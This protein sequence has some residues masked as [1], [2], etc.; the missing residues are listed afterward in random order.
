MEVYMGTI[1][2]FGFNFA[3]SGWQQCNGQ[4]LAIQ[5]YNALLALLGTNYGGNGSTNFQL[6]NL[7]GRVP[8]HQGN[9][10]GGS[11]YVIGQVGGTE[12]TSIS[13]TNMPIHTHT[14]P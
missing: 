8:I 14:I 13:P 3:P 1:M 11:T 5:Q 6:P 7:Q 9:L 10:T 12:N 4:T 2:A